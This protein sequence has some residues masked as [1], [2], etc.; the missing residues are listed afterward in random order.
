MLLAHQL[1][2]LD[3]EQYFAFTKSIREELLDR[4]L[5]LVPIEMAQHELVEGLDEA[6]VA[7]GLQ[8]EAAL[9]GYEARDKRRVYE[10]SVVN[11]GE[12]REWHAIEHLT[13]LHG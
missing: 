12:E 10:E 6:I 4:N 3:A 7:L 2:D 1:N 9:L 8:L 11:D 13:L 5:R